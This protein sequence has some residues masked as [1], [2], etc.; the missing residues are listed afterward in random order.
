MRPATIEDGRQLARIDASTWSTD[1]SPAP[2]PLNVTSFFD[3]RTAP[4]DVLVAEIDGGVVGYARLGQP[5][6]LASHEHVLELAGLA[7]D[8]AHRRLGIGRRLVDEAIDEARRRGAA[9]LSLRVLA[10]NVAA[11]RLYERRGFVVEGILRA[12]FLL[13]GHYVDDVLMAR[14]LSDDVRWEA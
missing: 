9:K 7:V 8:P 1:V 3:D 6:P 12:E 13:D 10:P 4:G 5:I 2:P 11:R 14:R